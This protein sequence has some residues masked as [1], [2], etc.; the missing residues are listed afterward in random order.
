MSFR[1]ISSTRTILTSDM[2]GD[3]P[4][5]LVGAL[6]SV[7]KGYVGVHLFRLSWNIPTKKEES[8]IRANNTGHATC[9]RGSATPLY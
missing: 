8:K 7:F 4:K 9:R 2:A 1:N 5:H 6:D 3:V